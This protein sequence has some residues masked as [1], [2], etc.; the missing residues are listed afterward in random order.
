MLRSE[1]HWRII[2][3]STVPDT[4]IYIA[5]I[6]EPAASLVRDIRGFGW[7]VQHRRIGCYLSVAIYSSHVEA[8]RSAAGRTETSGK[9]SAARGRRPKIHAVTDDQ[10]VPASCSSHQAT[11]TISRPH[12]LFSQRSDLSSG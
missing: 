5:S 2:I 4:T 12:R 11:S 7:E 6:V 8:H 3:R 10:D 9:P 1:A